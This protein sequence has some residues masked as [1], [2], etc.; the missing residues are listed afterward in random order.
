[1][2]SL[3]VLIGPKEIEADLGEHAVLE[4][5]KALIEGVVDCDLAAVACKR[6]T[7]SAVLVETS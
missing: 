3:S 7:T 1:M 2:Y 4:Q 6:N 5:T